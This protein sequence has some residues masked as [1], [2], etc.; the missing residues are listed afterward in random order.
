[1][2][3]LKM[4]YTYFI[5]SLKNKDIYIGSCQDVFIRFS[6]HNKGYVRSTKA[7]R[8]WEL[9]YY[10]RHSSRKEAL[11]KERFYKSREQRLIIREKFK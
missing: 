1:M 2:I 10:E 9:I 8:P 5:K 6:R 11:E 7:Y 3:L 4:F